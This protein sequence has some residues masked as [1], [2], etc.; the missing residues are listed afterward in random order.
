MPA[1]VMSYPSDS[2]QVPRE[3]NRQTTPSQERNLCLAEGDRVGHYWVSR[4]MLGTCCG[5][6]SDLSAA[7]N[8][9]N[10]PQNGS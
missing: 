7:C 9:E 6:L 10:D 2:M 8:P 3:S 4:H 5:L 1:F